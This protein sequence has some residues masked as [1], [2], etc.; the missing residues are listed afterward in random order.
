[1]SAFITSIS[2]EITELFSQQ[3]DRWI[4]RRIPRS[5]DI[6]LNQRH[7]FIFPSRAGLSFLALLL[8]LLLVAINYQNNL[9]FG[10]VFLLATV[11]VIAIHLTFANLHGLSVKGLANDPVFL[12]DHAQLTLDIASNSRARFSIKIALRHKTSEDDNPSGLVHEPMTAFLE[13]GSTCRSL[14]H[15]YPSNRGAFRPDR[16][17]IETHYPLGLVRCWSWLDVAQITWVYPCP[18]K[19]NISPEQASLDEHNE[20][21]LRLS[22]IK[23]LG[24]DLHSFRAYQK[25]DPI[26]HIH[27]PSFARGDAPL[28]DIRADNVA[29][30]QDIIDFDDYPNIDTETRL[31]WLCY[32]AVQAYEINR[33][34]VLRLAGREIDSQAGDIKHSEALMALA[35]FPNKPVPTWDS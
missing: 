8:V 5:Q 22:N 30:A 23:S 4:N 25:G 14:I 28:V 21:V 33:P 24:D 13:S 27:W 29:E 2:G 26:R 11:F 18:K 9:I 32:R 35:Q 34:F 6:T 15:A 17:L 31:S 7:L 20:S 10:L 1:M 12:G 3:W 16:L 19:P